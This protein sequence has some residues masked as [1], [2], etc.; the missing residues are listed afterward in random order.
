MQ[1]IVNQ[2]AALELPIFN[3]FV[4][5]NLTLDQCIVFES[6]QNPKPSM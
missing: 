6:T 4:A 5:L 3:V 2:A 1:A